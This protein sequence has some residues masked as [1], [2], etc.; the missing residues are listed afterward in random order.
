MPTAIP[1]AVVENYRVWLEAIGAT[2]ERLEEKSTTLYDTVAV[3][4]AE[5]EDLLEIEELGIR[6]DD[7]GYTRIDP[8][9]PKLRVATG[10]RDFEG[11][12][13][14]LVERLCA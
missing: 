2:P 13:D 11:F 12:H 9:G 1:A 6:V 7:E 8:S 14:M 4:L 10:W 3:H 5:T